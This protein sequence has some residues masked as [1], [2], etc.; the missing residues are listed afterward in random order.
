VH[1]LTH[2]ATESKIFNSLENIGGNVPLYSVANCARM[3]SMRMLCTFLYRATEDVVVLFLFL[4]RS[5]DNVC[6]KRETDCVQEAVQLR[7][8]TRLFTWCPLKRPKNRRHFTPSLRFE[9]NVFLTLC[10]TSLSKKCV[11]ISFDLWERKHCDFAL[12]PMTL[13]CT[14]Q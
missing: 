3:R 14:A 13:T 7:R 5:L 2:R 10:G 8:T 11:P 12:V 4:L 9:N 1:Q 6:E